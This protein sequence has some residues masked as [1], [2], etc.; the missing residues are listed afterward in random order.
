MSIW[1]ILRP[2]GIFYG[3]FVY[4]L[5][6]WNIFS[7]FGKLQQE[8]SGNPAQHLRGKKS[9]GVI[10]GELVVGHRGRVHETILRISPSVLIIQ[11]SA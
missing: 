1:Y 6:I 3:L 5:V 4:F 7:R 10:I 9:A 8:K 2:S 11:P